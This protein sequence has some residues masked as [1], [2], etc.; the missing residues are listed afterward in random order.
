M[1]LLCSG[2]WC[3]QQNAVRSSP[4][5]YKTTILSRFSISFQTSISKSIPG[6]P[7]MILAKEA[8]PRRYVH[9]R[10]L[11][12]EPEA[13]QITAQNDEPFSSP[14]RM[15][16]LLS[17]AKMLPPTLSWAQNYKKWCLRGRARGW[18][19]TVLAGVCVA[20]LVL[21]CNVILLV[22]TLTKPIDVRTNN[23]KILGNSCSQV[24]TIETWSHLAINLLS[25]CLLAS[26][27]YALQVLSSPTREEVDHY[28]ARCEYLDIG[29][30]GFWNLKA[31]TLRRKALWVLLAVSSIP[32]HLL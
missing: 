18:R 30:S 26:S 3:Y 16:T 9:V 28:H 12:N 8:A 6:I 31:L 27:N 23:R 10:D 11:C 25:T 4:S 22:W 19:A 14:S 1:L 15:Q 24:Q 2:N 17:K 5:C 20:L 32:L 13:M 21:L 29:I 7:P